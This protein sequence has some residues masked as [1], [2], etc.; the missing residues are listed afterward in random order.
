MQTLNRSQPSS[1]TEDTTNPAGSRY[2][3]ARNRRRVLCVFP[4]FAH[5]FATLDHA[6]PL[7]RA[8]ALM[9]PQ[10]HL[11]IAAYLPPEWEVRFVDENIGP[12]KASDYQW[13]DVVFLSGMHVQ[14][15]HLRSINQRAHAF[16]KLT[17]L[18]GP[19]VSACP[20]WYDEVDS[21][22][23][24]ELGDGTDALLARLDES[25]A[26]PDRQETYTTRE[27][28]PLAAFPIPAY[29]L[30]KLQNYASGS[31][32]YSSGCPYLCE[33]CDIPE[34]Y[35]RNP[36]LKTP[37][38]LT[39]ELD[40]MIAEF[41]P[42]AV[43]FVD[44]NFIGNRRA[45]RALLHELVR[46][47]QER[48][49]PLM[50][51]CE[52]TLNLAQEPEL[53]ELMREANFI[54]VFYGIESPEESA[55]KLMHKEQN[56]RQPIVDAVR[57]TNSYGLEL[58]GGII[59]GFDT[60]T[61]KTGER[62]AEFIEE[63]QIPFFTINIL[64]ALPQTPLWR[65]LEAAG[66]LRDD[67]S[68]DSNVDFLLPYEAVVEMWRTCVR[69]LYAP[70]AIYGRLDYQLRHTYPNRKTIP[71]SQANYSWAD[72]K[73]GLS[74][75]A[76]VFW[77]VGLRSHYR[78]RFWR[79]AWAAL[80]QGRLTEL[81]SLAFQAHHMILYAI[82]CTREEACSSNYC[83]LAEKFEFAGQAREDSAQ[84]VR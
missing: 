55:L 75:L 43:Y 57:K 25:V 52:A 10:G 73:Y 53:L 72:V 13:A 54:T 62:I 34:L 60:D 49:Y 67:P 30:V 15:D 65:R 41:K 48:N 69:R 29:N 63:A 78:R 61:L 7:L 2:R 59:F 79:T 64:Q 36:R 21:L 1:P 42:R 71:L 33:F 46:W 68:R 84:S 81:V 51:S 40:A 47:Q 20:D 17:V 66:R 14:R 39:S 58:W 24:G 8:Q 22:H 44:D 37:R 32:Q 19:S 3:A 76:A 28:L 9:P 27:R 11:V 45:T 38:Q 23:I 35:G 83:P 77:H 6:L 18:G 74:V 12:A 56:L 50:F 80:R 31:V 4:R 16:N 26:R 5:S 82:E 70:D